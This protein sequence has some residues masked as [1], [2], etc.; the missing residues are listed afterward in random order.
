MGRKKA[1][2]LAE[3]LD[4]L[5]MGAEPGDILKRYP[6]YTEELSGLLEVAKR[7]RAT[8]PNFQVLPQPERIA[9]LLRLPEL[10]EREP[11]TDR[12][13][14]GFVV[15]ALALSVLLLQTGITTALGLGA[16]A[17]GLGV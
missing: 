17:L 5:L 8:A 7:V 6:R 4:A 16:M 1:D 9:Y 3:C 13:Y 12:L 2:V 11:D 15:I 14:S 10:P